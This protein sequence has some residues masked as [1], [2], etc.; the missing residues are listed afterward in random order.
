MLDV[1]TAMLDQA[2]LDQGSQGSKKSSQT[3]W[4]VVYQ[5]RTATLDQWREYIFNGETR[6][7][8][9]KNPGYRKEEPD[10]WKG[11]GKGYPEDFW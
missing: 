6:F 11:F 8:T 7:L 2:L 3:V 4:K 1:V 5:E 10:G 9:L